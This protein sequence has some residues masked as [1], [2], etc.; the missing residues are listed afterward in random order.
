MARY[1]TTRRTRDD[2]EHRIEIIKEGLDQGH[3]KCPEKIARLTEEVRL[4][5]EAEAQEEASHKAFQDK[6]GHLN[7]WEFLQTLKGETQ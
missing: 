1:K 6:Y 4:W 5:D 7:A 3:Y 2:E